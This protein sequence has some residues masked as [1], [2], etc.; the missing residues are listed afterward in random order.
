MGSPG[1]PYLSFFQF[2]RES[3]W[4]TAVAC[5]NRI[6]I[7]PGFQPRSE[8]GRIFSPAFDGKRNPVTA[9]IGGK[10]SRLTAEF[11]L[12]YTGML[13]LIDGLMG[14]ATF[15]NNGGTTSGAGPYTHTFIQRLIYNSYTLQFGI[16]DVPA[17]KCEQ[18]AG[19]KIQEA[20]FSCSGAFDSHEAVVR[21]RFVFIGGNYSTN[22]TPT[23]LSA[24]APDPA[25]FY[26]CTNDTDGSGD[27]ADDVQIRGFE[28][29]VRN[30]LTENRFILEATNPGVL[31]EPLLTGK[32]S[33]I[34]MTIMEEF[35]T[36][37]I[38]ESFWNT[39]ATSS[40]VIR[41]TSGTKDITFTLP[42]A[43]ISETPEHDP[44]GDDIIIQ[45][46]K[47]RA[48][49]GGSNSGLTIVVNNAQSLINA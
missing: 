13:L 11:E 26:H 20:T 35:R 47:W 14:T 10:R 6:P 23:S 40:P 49:D 12:T 46:V 5:T 48:L 2:G 32:K 42:V 16:G 17:T 41:F 45:N 1:F 34:I 21:V 7:L 3:T 39:Y 37:T 24:A 28:L 36:K 19:A 44:T 38:L 22:V 27:A 8:A 43:A 31:K 33:E 18:I 4:N 15:G 29:V 25:L 30:F 9:Y